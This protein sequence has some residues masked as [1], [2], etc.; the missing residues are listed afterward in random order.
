ML[1]TI[2]LII[3]PVSHSIS[4]KGNAI[5]SSNSFDILSLL[6]ITSKVNSRLADYVLPEVFKDEEL[7]QD[8]PI[9]AELKKK[10]LMVISG[11]VH[12]GE[13]NSSFMMEGFLNYVLGDSLEA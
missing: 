5:L 2:G 9:P 13:S 1:I 3:F 8:T 10:R 7:G 12:P 11:R 6:T 4:Y